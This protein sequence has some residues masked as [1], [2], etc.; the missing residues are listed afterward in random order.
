VR[1]R[2]DKAMTGEMLAAI[3]HATLQQTVHQ[4]FSQKRGD[5][6]VAVERTVD[7]LINGMVEAVVREQWLP[8]EASDLRRLALLPTTPSPEWDALMVQPSYMQALSLLP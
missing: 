1:I 6:W 8:C 2:F 4:T 7:E 5:A 3:G